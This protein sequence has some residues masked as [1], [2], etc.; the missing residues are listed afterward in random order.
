MLTGI[1]PVSGVPELPLPPSVAVRTG[2]IHNVPLL[3][4][5]TRDEVRQWALPF[6]QATREQYE[7]AVRLEFDPRTADT[8]LAHYPYSAYDRPYVGTYAISAP[9]NDS[10]V[11]YG[12]GGCEYQ[13]LTARFAARQPRTYFY[14]FDDPHPPTLATT[15]PGFDSRAPH[16]SELGYLWPM[17]TSE[18]QTPEQR[19]LSTAMVGYWGAFVKLAN[20]TTAGLAAWPSYGSGKYMSLLPGDDSQ[21]LKSWVYADRHQCGFWNSIDYGRL[22]T[23]P[24]RLAAQAG[25]PTS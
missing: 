13:N 22:T 25:V 17:K 19:Q 9:W 3:I 15:P 10:S 7:R 24:D 20:P 11:F 5:S 14:Q 18:S 6:A 2:R 8:V 23:D 4:G 1:L 16:A 12:L 21:A